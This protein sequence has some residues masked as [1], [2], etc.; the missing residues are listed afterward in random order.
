MSHVGQ[1]DSMK[2]QSL[3]IVDYD[4]PK[5]NKRRQFYRYLKR[6]LNEC[7]WKKSSDSVILVD[8]LRTA[9]AVV[10]LARA[11]NAHHANVYKCEPLTKD[12]LY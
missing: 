12:V 11:Y 3:Y 6:V 9:L 10:D 4:L 5:G 7:R 1:G 8:N 2:S